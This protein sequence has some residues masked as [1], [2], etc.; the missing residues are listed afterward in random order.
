MST[1]PITFDHI[2]LRIG[3]LGKY[4]ISQFGF[5][6]IF[7][8]AASIISLSMMFVVATPSHLCAPSVQPLSLNSTQVSFTLF[9]NNSN[10]SLYSFEVYTIPAFKLLHSY[11]IFYN[12]LE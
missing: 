10:F 1:E 5:A 11:A 12:F 4:Q 3:E 7:I 6:G 2:V 8:S 9:N